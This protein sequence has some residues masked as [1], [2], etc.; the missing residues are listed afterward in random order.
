[1]IWIGT[2]KG[3]INLLSP[4]QHLFLNLGNIPGNPGS[5]SKYPV[6]AIYEDNDGD[7]FVGIVEGG[8]NIHKKG[9]DSFIHS[10]SQIG[11]RQSLSHNLVCS[12]CQDYNKNYWKRYQ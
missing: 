4:D 3:D 2:D 10:V 8:L 1:M 7:L 9:T 12:I 5:L 6:N 11:N